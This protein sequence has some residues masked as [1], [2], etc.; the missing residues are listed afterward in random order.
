MHFRCLSHVASIYHC[1]RAWFSYLSHIISAS[2]EDLLAI[3]GQHKWQQAL[4]KT[5]GLADVVSRA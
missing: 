4:E 1:R 2:S 3:L 5:G